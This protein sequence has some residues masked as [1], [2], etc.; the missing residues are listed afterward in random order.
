MTFS[1]VNFNVVALKCL[2]RNAMKKN[3]KK[4]GIKSCFNTSLIFTCKDDNCHKPR[5]QDNHKIDANH[6]I[7]QLLVIILFTHE[8]F[9][10]EW[11][12]KKKIKHTTTTQIP[13]NKKTK[14]F[15]GQKKKNNK[16]TNPQ[17]K[18]KYEKE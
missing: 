14:H 10:V 9:W 16:Q 6:S 11:R 13:T 3:W 2:W 7:A 8:P 1:N 15:T 5:E 17:Q 12:N 18:N 4:T